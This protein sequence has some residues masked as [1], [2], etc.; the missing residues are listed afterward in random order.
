MDI[1][2]MYYFVQIMK[3]RNMTLAAKHL[4]IS[5][6]A[7]SKALKKMEQE[8]NEPLFERL[9]NGL[10]PTSR[11]LILYDKVLDILQHY[12]ELDMF[13]HGRSTQLRGR[14]RIGL[15]PVI[16]SAIFVPII[17]T[18]KKKFPLI[19]LELIECGAKLVE[20]QLEKY[21]LDVGIVIAPVEKK[22][23]FIPLV[24]EE[25]VVVL[26]KSHPLSKQ[27]TITLR[28]L[29]HEQLLLL[30]QSFSLHH[31]I[32]EK[33]KMNGF[34]ANVALESSQWDFLIK[35]MQH[36]QGITIL[37]EP[38]IRESLKTHAD[39]VKLSF[40]PRFDWTIGF[41]TRAQHPIAPLANCFIDHALQWSDNQKL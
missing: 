31:Q 24:T 3:D 32:I 23:R 18:F 6:P 15:P 20:Q 39:L 19:E 29:A 4:H 1:R 14:L 13:M 10:F 27:P 36:G 2:E 16:G 22:F 17:A 11:A 25:V 38:I 21:Q 33:C 35:M 30:N 9:E 40:S 34:E 37:P 7:L 12:E 41:I 5:Q 28:E 26:P 8:Y